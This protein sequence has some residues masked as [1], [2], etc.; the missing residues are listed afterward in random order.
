MTSKVFPPGKWVRLLGR[1]AVMFSVGQTWT[2]AR[3]NFATELQRVA[4]VGGGQRVPFGDTLS[5]G[6]EG[7]GKFPLVLRLVLWLWVCLFSEVLFCSFSTCDFE[8]PAD[9]D[10]G[11]LLTPLEEMWPPIV[12][13][14]HLL[15][16]ELCP[17]HGQ[18]DR[19][20][21]ASSLDWLLSYLGDDSNYRLFRSYQFLNF[22]VGPQVLRYS[23]VWSGRC[24]G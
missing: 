6:E 12:P 17:T 24:S 15:W 22:L 16:V 13:E 10:K 14:C 7:Q 19:V 1:E 4:G 18:H 21:L 11:K 23:Y 3:R 9:F 2:V 20:V 8:T 5:L